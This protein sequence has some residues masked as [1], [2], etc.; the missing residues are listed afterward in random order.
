MNSGKKLNRKLKA[1]ALRRLPY[2]ISCKDLE[3]FIVDYVDETLP[4]RQ[5]K[6]FEVHLLVCSSC[7]AYIDNYK[8][9]IEL[10]RAAYDEK[11]QAS[12]DDMPEDLVNAILKS[13]GNARQ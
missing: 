1:W 11:D 8:Q 9:T 12:C 5:R 10:S 6:K 13:R 7:Q 4:A 3:A 2:M